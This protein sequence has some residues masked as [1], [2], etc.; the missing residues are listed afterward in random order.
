MVDTLVRSLWLSTGGAT[1]CVVLTALIAYIVHRSRAPG[2][3]VLEQVSVMPIGIPG[4]VMGMAMIWAYITWPLWGTIWI[5]IIAYMTLFMPY[6]VR[7]LGSNI[8]Q[9][10][11][12]LEGRAACTARRG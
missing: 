8:V 3:K 9:I 6:G 4:I 1:L 7:A 12:E 2:R 11:P 10:H 5:L